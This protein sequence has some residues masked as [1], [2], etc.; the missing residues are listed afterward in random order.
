VSKRN[1]IADLPQRWRERAEQIH[2]EAK[3]QPTAAGRASQRTAAATIA[4]LA[5]ELESYLDEDAPDE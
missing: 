2:H 4:S 1:P 5:A 3:A